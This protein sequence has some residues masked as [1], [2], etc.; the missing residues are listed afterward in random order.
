MEEGQEGDEDN[1]E[2]AEADGRM[3]PVCVA[4]MLPDPST[5]DTLPMDVEPQEYIAP[6]QHAGEL[7]HA[8]EV[9]QGSGGGVGPL[10]VDAAESRLQF[11]RRLGSTSAKPITLPR[12]LRVGGWYAG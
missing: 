4:A 2:W 7:E 12:Y 6:S 3:E 5:F 8:E 11:L 10:E 9:A 1:D